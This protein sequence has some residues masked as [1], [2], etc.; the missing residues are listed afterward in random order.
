MFFFH[1]IITTSWWHQSIHCATN[2]SMVATNISYIHNPLQLQLVTPFPNEIHF[3]GTNHLLQTPPIQFTWPTILLTAIILQWNDT[4][5]FLAFA[6]FNVAPFIFLMTSLV[7]MW[8]LQN[9]TIHFKMTPLILKW[10]H[11]FLSDTNHFTDLVTEQ[12]YCKQMHHWQHCNFALKSKF[13]INVVFA[14]MGL[15]N[16]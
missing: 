10:H 15:Q 5:R 8:P 7:H 2:Y 1:S 14:T 12:N 4:M 11:W 6:R 9:D 16:S 3:S 13:F